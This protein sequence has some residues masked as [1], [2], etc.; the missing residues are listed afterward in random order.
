MAFI[1]RLTRAILKKSK[2]IQ[3]MKPNANRA[4]PVLDISSQVCQ[5]IGSNN[6]RRPRTV[7][8]GIMKAIVSLK[9]SNPIPRI[10]SSFN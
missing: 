8:G 2:N 6:K 4:N 9:A 3:I 1:I 10:G 7:N 5:P